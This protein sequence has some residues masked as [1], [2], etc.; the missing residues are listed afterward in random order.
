MVMEFKFGL[1]EQGMKDT[2]NKIKL[3]EKESFGMLMEMFLKVSGKMIKQMD[4][5]SIFT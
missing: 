2:G 1:T 4:M 5:E 3:V